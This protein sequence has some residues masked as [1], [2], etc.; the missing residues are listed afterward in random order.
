MRLKKAATAKRNLVAE[1]EL[2]KM[3]EREIKNL[4]IM[5]WCWRCDGTSLFSTAAEAAAAAAEAASTAA[6]E[7][8][9]AVG[10]REAYPRQARRARR[11][12]LLGGCG[13]DLKYVT[14]V[15]IFCCVVP[16]QKSR[17]KTLNTSIDG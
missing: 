10:K 15:C 8:A 3:Q 6:T 17:V 14:S 11:I 5:R 9:F 1:H 16:V 4:C 2:G 12:A 13:G 7:P